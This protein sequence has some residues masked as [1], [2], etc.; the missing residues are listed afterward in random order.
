MR[1]QNIVTFELILGWWYEVVEGLDED[2]LDRVITQSHTKVWHIKEVSVVYLELRVQKCGWQS[3][4]SSWSNMVEDIGRQLK[5]YGVCPK[6]IF[7]C[8]AHDNLWV[9]HSLERH[10][11][12]FSVQA[13][14]D[15]RK[16]MRKLLKCIVIHDHFIFLCLLG[17]IQD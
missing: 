5:A 16:S 9:W 10:L 1:E 14:L 7:L 3:K 8:V 2:I 15:T 6:A 12:N 17:F 13:E 11:Y 4:I